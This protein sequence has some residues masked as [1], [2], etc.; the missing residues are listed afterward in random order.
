MQDDVAARAVLEQA[1]YRVGA[2]DGL[3]HVSAV[4]EPAAITRLLGGHGHWLAELT[5]V[6][7]D[8]E[9]VILALT[10]QDA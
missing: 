10:E 4:A 8:L 1:G 9:D 2:A 5:P 3:L 6:A 7:V